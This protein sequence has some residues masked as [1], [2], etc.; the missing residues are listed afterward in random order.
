MLRGIECLGHSTIKF[1]KMEKQYIYPYNLK[2]I[3]NEDT[4]IIETED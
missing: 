2:E 4:I 3:R 1:T